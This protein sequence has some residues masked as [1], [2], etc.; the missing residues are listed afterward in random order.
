MKKITV[1]LVDDHAVVRQ[2]LRALLRCEEDI[3]VVGEAE[4]GGQAVTL[5]REK[6]PDVIVMDVAMPQMNGM[7]ATRH[8]LRSCRSSAVLVLSSYMESTCVE[9]LFQAGAAGYVLKQGAG[10]ELPKAIREV[11]RGNRFLSA[12]LADEK[13]RDRVWSRRLDGTNREL[14]SREIQVLQLVAKGFSN[15]EA[16]VELAISIKTIEKHR[17]QVMNKLNIHETAGL[18][19][20]ALAHGVVKPLKAGALAEVGL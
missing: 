3:E 17:Q 11:R 13:E 15:R 7:D 12:V 10:G 16:A 4:D 9:Q 18:T 2:G 5:A 20:Y 14:T 8:V 19:R 6:Q 1:L